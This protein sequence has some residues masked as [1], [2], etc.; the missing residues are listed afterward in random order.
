MHRNVLLQNYR[1]LYENGYSCASHAF[2]RGIGKHLFAF[3]PEVISL[4]HEC[5]V[6]PEIPVLPS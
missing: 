5:K 2:D 3:F 4:H 6:A 1:Q